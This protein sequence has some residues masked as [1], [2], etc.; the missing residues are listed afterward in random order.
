MVDTHAHIYH[1]RLLPEIEQVMQRCT[2]QNVHKVYMPNIDHES[3][4]DMLQVEQ[5]FPER[6]FAM[7]GVHPCSVN[8]QSIE[9]ELQTVES[10]LQ[11]RPFV[12]VGEMGLDLYWDKTTLEAQKEA[13]RVQANWAKELDLPIVIHCRDAFEPTIE[14][15]EELQD[16]RLKGI[17][18]C[19][20]DGLEE[21]Q[22]TIE[23]GFLIGLG[24]VSTFK[25]GGLGPVMQQIDLQHI[26]LETDSPFLA[27]VPHRGKRNEP[28]YVALVAQTLANAKGI[29]I[30]E[31]DQVTTQNAFTLFKK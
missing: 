31:V 14:L 2:Q 10:W 13:F 18:H 6:C 9:K 28:A 23:A 27:P 20:V 5:A 7:M 1:K 17:F 25:N 4:D 8:P 15:V 16:G 11:K 12:A 3:I 19:W 26:V 21:A 30:D 24:G 22:R 29:S